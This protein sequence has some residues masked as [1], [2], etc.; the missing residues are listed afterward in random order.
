MNTRYERL[1]MVIGEE[2]VDK[3]T[4]C[5]VAVVGIGGVGGICAEALARSG[6]GHLVLVDGDTVEPT[7]INRQVVAFTSTVGKNKA[8]LMAGQV[9]DIGEDIDVQVYPVFLTND[10]V[11]LEGLDYVVDAIDSAD[12]KVA[13]AARCRALG[14]PLIAAMGAGSKR[15]P[16]AFRVMRIE[17]TAVDPF[18][19]VMR[20][21]YKDAGI[22]GVK[23][24]C[25]MEKPVK[26]GSATPGSFMPAVAAAGLLM[27]AEVIKDLLG[28]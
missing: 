16:M 6:I 14:I 27:A 21:K 2:S 1:A 28:Q 10:E 13:L 7:N 9:R 24:V 26:T 15:D 12:D 4:R 22:E 3:L 19:K 18:A 5:R 11:P 25:S 20:K 8:G 17:E 23:V